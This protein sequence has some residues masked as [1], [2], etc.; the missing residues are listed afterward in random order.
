MV[1]LPLRAGAGRDSC[2]KLP[3]AA[4]VPSPR[5]GLPHPWSGTGRPGGP[6]DGSAHRC[7]LQL[8]HVKVGLV[9]KPTRQLES[10]GP[11]GSGL[12]GRCRRE[13]YD[14]GREH[15]DRVLE[16]S[17]VDRSV[18]ADQR[19][20]HRAGQQQVRNLWANIGAFHLTLWAHCLTELWAWFQPK[21]ALCDRSDSPWDDAARRPSHADRRK[22]L[23]RS[24]LAEEFS[25]L[26]RRLTIASEIQQF[27]TGLIYQAA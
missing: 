26:K 15:G 17:V 2:R 27:I 20:E 25:F 1:P 18:Q 5:P 19:G 4:A 3:H 11:A 13:R 6:A 16:Q 21:E 24:C 12:A 7:Q 22:A 8:G 23:Q 10:S 14:A 9:R